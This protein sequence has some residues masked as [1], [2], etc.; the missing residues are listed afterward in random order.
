[1]V[2][3]KRT[4]V[5]QFSSDGAAY[6]TEINFHAQH[7][8]RLG[9]PNGSNQPIDSFAAQTVTIPMSATLAQLNLRLYPV[10]S[11]ATVAPHQPS[12]AGD[13]Q[14]VSI[15]PS[16]T[17]AISTTLLW[18]LSNAQ[19]WQRTSFDLTPFAGQT[20][21]LRLGVIND[22]QGGQT[23]LYVDNASLITL[24]PGGSKVFLPVI[25]KHYTN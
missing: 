24:G 5:G 12:G 7:A 3:R 17:A 23:A 18:T 22:G 14:Y 16:D 21:E 15:I 1:M 6:A 8:L 19:S 4:A 25:L 2:M 11:E 9:L 20:V 13:A 10:S